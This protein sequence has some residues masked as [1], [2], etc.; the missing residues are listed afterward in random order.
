MLARTPTLGTEHEL[1]ER[2]ADL[3]E[4]IIQLRE[5]FSPK[6]GFPLAWGLDARD[7]AILSALFHNRGSYVTPEALLL[8]IEG[9]DEDQGISHVRVWVGR[10]RTKVVKHGI[11]IATRPREG[12]S[13]D[14]AGRAVVA[15]AL[16]GAVS[17]APAQP[18]PAPRPQPNAWC[19]AQDRIVRAGY[20][21]NATKAVIRAEL[22]AAKFPARRLHAISSRAQDLGI[23]RSRAETV[24]C[25]AEDDILRDGREAGDSPLAIK[26]NLAQ[27]GFTRSRAAIQMRALTLNL[28]P[29]RSVPLTDAEKDAIK[30]GLAAGETYVTIFERLKARGCQHGRGT[31]EAFG[32]ALG[33][34]RSGKPWLPADVEL[35]RELCAARL[36]HHEIAARL[37][38]PPSSVQ[39]KAS[40]MGFLQRQK[41]LPEDRQRVIDGHARGESPREIAAA[42][43]R[44]Y[45]NVLAEANRLGLRFSRQNRKA[46]ADA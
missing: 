33:V 7:T 21:R 35:L 46:Q 41:W 5:A 4:Q 1:R 6:V 40:E 39:D 16:G 8:L 3:E 19:E 29:K 45:P 15:R 32:R 44:P 13:L 43:G 14:P 30:V 38:R 25:R 2:I 24:W 28:C 11:E 37:G 31:I 22:V 20:A 12:Y 26:L 42:L 36:P 34:R 9:F 18:A 17:V 23:A 10:L 27:A